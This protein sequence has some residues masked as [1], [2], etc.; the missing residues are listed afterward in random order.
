MHE[1]V[2]NKSKSLNTQT[3]SVLTSGAGEAKVKNCRPSNDDIVHHGSTA[4]TGNDSI[5]GPLQ[6]LG[7]SDAL[8]FKR[9]ERDAV[10][11]DESNVEAGSRG[12][13]CECCVLAGRDGAGCNGEGG[14]GFHRKNR[15]C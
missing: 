12:V 15:V 4:R 13:E 8:V 7:D 6:T 11:T 10:R 5:D 9:G 2:R 1:N 14:E 3:K